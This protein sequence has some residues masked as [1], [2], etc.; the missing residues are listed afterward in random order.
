MQQRTGSFKKNLLK[1]KKAT[2]FFSDSFLF[3][4]IPILHSVLFILPHLS[5]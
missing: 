1:N 2:R 5:Y 4:S 3:I